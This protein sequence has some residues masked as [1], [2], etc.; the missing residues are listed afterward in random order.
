MA[1]DAILSKCF[2]MLHAPYESN[3]MRI[4]FTKLST[5]V[6]KSTLLSS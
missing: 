3:I 2:S 5:K 1:R 4:I 6:R